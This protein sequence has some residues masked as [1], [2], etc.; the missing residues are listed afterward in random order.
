M[1]R[2]QGSGYI[3]RSGGTD[4]DVLVFL[5]RDGDATVI[6]SV[7]FPSHD[8]KWEHSPIGVIIKNGLDQQ[9][10][11]FSRRIGII[12]FLLKNT[13]F[14]FR[15][16]VAG[17]MNRKNPDEGIERTFYEGERRA[18]SFDKVNSADIVLI[19]GEIVD[20]HVYEKVKVGGGNS[21]PFGNYEFQAVPETFACGRSGIV[22]GLFVVVIVLHFGFPPC[23][24]EFVEMC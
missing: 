14:A 12:G 16:R 24:F 23:D 3:V 19:Q 1:Y 4:D 15:K 2:T 20:G 9:K 11:K 18:L 13:E 6:G 22:V 10:I 21:F 8:A 7:K 17:N 5:V